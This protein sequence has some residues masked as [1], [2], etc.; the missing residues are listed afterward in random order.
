MI[1]PADGEELILS[2]SALRS[3]LPNKT[4]GD[5]ANDSDGLV[6]GGRKQSFDV[7]PFCVSV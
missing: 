1:A 7:A 6:G 4:G 5:S 3:S 2:S